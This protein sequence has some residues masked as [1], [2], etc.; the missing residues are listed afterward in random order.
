[1]ELAETKMVPELDVRAGMG[2][3]GGDPALLDGSVPV[4]AEWHVPEAVLRQLAPGPLPG[5]AFITA[6]GDS[7]EPIIAPNTR[8]LVNTNDRGPSPPGLYIVYDGFALIIKRVEAIPFSD[9]PTVRISS[10]NPAY[11]PYERTLE[12]AYIQGRVVAQL[13]AT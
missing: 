8:V 11:Q 9:P 6:I 1:V 5:L 13:K 2:A 7:N 4:V 3:L 12:E 10:V